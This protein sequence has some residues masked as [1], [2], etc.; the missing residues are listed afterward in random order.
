MEL[1]HGKRGFIADSLDPERSPEPNQFPREKSPR[2]HNWELPCLGNH[3]QLGTQ[4]SLRLKARV[5]SA[6]KA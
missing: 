3:S 2:W 1:W 4:S 5:C 6:K